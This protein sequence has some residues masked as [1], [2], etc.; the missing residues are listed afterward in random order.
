MARVH[1]DLTDRIRVLRRLDFPQPA[2]IAATYDEHGKILKALRQKRADPAA[3]LLSAHIGSSQ[4]EV[5]KVTLHQVY[6]AK[7]G[8]LGRPV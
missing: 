2:R 5:R 8:A 6:L 4:V 7:A 1:S 3:L